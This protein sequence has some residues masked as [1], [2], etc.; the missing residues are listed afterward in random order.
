MSSLFFIGLTKIVFGFLVGVVGVFLASRLFDRLIGAR[1]SDDA[2]GEGNVSLAILKGAGLIALGILCRNAVLSAFAALDYLQFAGAQSW[3]LS[4]RMALHAV[5]HTAIAL[6]VGACVLAAGTLLF[7]RLTGG[8]EELK[9]IRA[10]NVAPGI[11]VGAVLIVLAL[12][13]APGLQ[14]VLDGLLPVPEL[15]EGVLPQPR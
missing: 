9:H 5:T 15:P 8:V 11:V 12:L 13:T 7:D 3:E 10:G 2:V 1:K 6:L 14:T 4:A